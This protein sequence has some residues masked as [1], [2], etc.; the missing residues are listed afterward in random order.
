LVAADGARFESHGESIFAH[1]PYMAPRKDPETGAVQASGTGTAY[2]RFTVD[3]PEGGAQ[4]FLA[5][6]AMDQGAI[7]PNR[8]D[9]VTFSVSA[10]SGDDHFH[11]ELHNPIVVQPSRLHNATDQRR[12]LE[13]DLTPLAGSRVIVELAVHPGPNRAPSFDW[14]RWH[15]PRIERKTQTEGTLA[16]TGPIPWKL[17]LSGS[18]P[19]AMQSEGR[20][21]RVRVPFPGTVLF[22][23]EEPAEVELPV[24]LARQP[25]LVGRLGAGGLAVDAPRFADVTPGRAAVC[26]VERDG[27]HAHPPNQG[28]TIAHFPM[29]LPKTSAAVHSWIGLRDGSQSTGVVFTIEVNGREVA[30]RRMLPGDS[31][32]LTADLSPWAGAPIVLALVTDSDGPFNFDWAHWGE[33][34]IQQR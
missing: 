22:L 16:V 34:T 5:H 15:K 9:G 23:R 8:T 13:L 30:R 1:P 20:L 3:L 7:G 10:R 18:G 6:V 19:L 32:C 17:A 4:R 26:G 31:H 27:L 14:A 33:P 24:D 29:T 2:A 25:R 12:P 21:R 11:R 28:R